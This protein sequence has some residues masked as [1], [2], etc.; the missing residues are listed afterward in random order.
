[1]DCKTCVN[2]KPIEAQK[3]TDHPSRI[4]AEDL[5]VGMVIRRHGVESQRNLAVILGE[6]DGTFVPALQLLTGYKPVYYDLALTLSGL[7]PRREGGW[8]GGKYHHAGSWV[9]DAWCEEVT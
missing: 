3:P 1:M 8:R 6:S 9:D 7:Q 4:F 2:Y 5:R